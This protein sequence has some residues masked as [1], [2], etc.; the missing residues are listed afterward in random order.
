MPKFEKGQSG[1]PKGRPPKDRELTS[2]LEAVGRRGI[3]TADGV[4]VA[5]RKL[6]AEHIWN[7]VTT[8]QT[9]MPDGSILKPRPRDYL[10]LMRWLYTHIDGPPP[11]KVQMSGPDGEPQVLRVE[12]VD[13][14]DQTA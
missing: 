3:E 11:S 5:R 13:A 6:A 4:R 10:E 1:N 9:T 2:I 14:D 8:G 12:Y 7:I